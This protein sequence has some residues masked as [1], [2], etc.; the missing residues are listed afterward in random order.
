[1]TEE[2]KEQ[3]RVAF[4][5]YMQ[6]VVDLVQDPCVERVETMEDLSTKWLEWNLL[7]RPRDM[8]YEQ[9]TKLFFDMCEW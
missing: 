7:N 1:M 3:G 5:K 2:Q 9:A 8:T 6:A 4:L